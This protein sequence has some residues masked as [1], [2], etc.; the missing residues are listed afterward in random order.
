MTKCECIDLT[1]SGSGSDSDFIQATCHFC[2]Y[3]IRFCIR[4][5][6][7]RVPATTENYFTGLVIVVVMHC[8]LTKSGRLIC[9]VRSWE[10]RFMMLTSVRARRSTGSGR[11]MSLDLSKCFSRIGCWAYGRWLCCYTK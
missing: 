1:P 5:L 3:Y 9:I 6:L 10:F 11:K 8:S 7:H 2:T 4:F